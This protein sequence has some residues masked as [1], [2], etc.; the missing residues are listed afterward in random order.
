MSIFHSINTVFAFLLVCLV[1]IVSFLRSTEF[2]GLVFWGVLG[3][4]NDI[5]SLGFSFF[6][7]GLM[8]N[9]HI[10]VL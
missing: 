3:F 9:L 4:F 8:N 2:L 7:P 1:F 5:I 6:S 10:T